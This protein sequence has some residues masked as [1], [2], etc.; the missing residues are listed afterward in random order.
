MRCPGTDRQLVWTSSKFCLMRTWLTSLIFSYSSTLTVAVSTCSSAHLSSSRFG[1]TRGDMHRWSS[2]SRAQSSTRRFWETLRR[3][4]RIP[5]SCFVFARLRACT[6]P[7][8]QCD[9]DAHFAAHNI[10]FDLT[11]CE[12]RFINPNKHLTEIKGGDWAGQDSVY[13]S[14]GCPSTCVG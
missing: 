12:W 4:F 11:L 7:L 10:I 2:R 8:T 1:S 5:R 14:S 6:H 9:I 13:A 3:S